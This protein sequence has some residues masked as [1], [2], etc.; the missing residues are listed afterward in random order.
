MRYIKIL[1]PQLFII[2]SLGGL[3][4]QRLP[5]CP[6]PLDELSGF[7]REGN[8][9]V[10]SRPVGPTPPAE[11]CNLQAQWLLHWQEVMWG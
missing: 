7:Q 3:I 5:V 6:D 11:T 8:S 4:N 9:H 2:L 10:Q 1:R